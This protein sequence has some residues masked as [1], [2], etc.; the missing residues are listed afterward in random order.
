MSKVFEETHRNFDINTSIAHAR[1]LQ[2]ST[3]YQHV[4]DASANS[5]CDTAVKVTQFLTLTL[6]VLNSGDDVERTGS[7]VELRTLD[8]ENPGANSVLRC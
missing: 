4:S 5:F 8:Y 2:L 7:R 6:N 3:M 1:R